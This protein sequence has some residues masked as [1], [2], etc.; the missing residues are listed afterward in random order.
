MK[1]NPT[2]DSTSSDVDAFATPIVSACQPGIFG[3]IESSMAT[4]NDDFLIPSFEYK[5]NQVVEIQ[6]PDG[7]KV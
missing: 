7:K 5:W 2:D 4:I 3:V 1:I 6:L